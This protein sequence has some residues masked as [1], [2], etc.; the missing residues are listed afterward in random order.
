MERTS[1]LLRNH[2]L[3]LLFFKEKNKVDDLPL[4]QYF[5]GKVRTC[6]FMV[7]KVHSGEN[8]EDNYQQ[9]NIINDGSLVVQPWIFG[10]SAM[11]LWLF[12]S[13][14]RKKIP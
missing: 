6:H 4:V 13:P 2:H 1:P 8:G 9:E 7:W 14:H 11:D 10:C 3:N 12:S 5:F